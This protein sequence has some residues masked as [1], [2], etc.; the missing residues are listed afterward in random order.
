M[1]YLVD[2]EKKRVIGFYES[3]KGLK[4]GIDLLSSV[5]QLPTDYHITSE[6]PECFKTVLLERSRNPK[7]IIINNSVTE[8]KSLPIKKKN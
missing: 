6:E 5:S 3:P 4:R 2:N 1:L 8:S 7:K